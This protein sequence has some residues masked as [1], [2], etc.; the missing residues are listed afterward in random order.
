MT[1][2]AKSPTRCVQQFCISGPMGNVEPN[3]SNDCTELT[4]DVTDQNDF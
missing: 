1:T 2:A 4:I 3:T